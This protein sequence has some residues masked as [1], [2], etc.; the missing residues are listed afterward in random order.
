[1]ERLI[2]FAK[3]HWTSIIL[4]VV[5]AVGI[6][7]LLYPTLSDM[8]NSRSHTRAIVNYVESVDL[9]KTEEL[10]ELREQ[11]QRYNNNLLKK[12]SR[13]HPDGAEHA[14]YMNLLNPSA[15]SIMAYLS[16]PK[17]SVS[18]PVYHTTDETVLQKAVGHFEGSSLP[19]GGE[20]TH[21]V[22]SGH[23]GLPSA[24]L[25][26]DLDKMLIGDVFQI[27][28]LEETLTYEIDQ[29]LITE[30]GDI[31]ALDIIDGED[32]CTI[33]TCT[34]YGI[35]T[36]RLLV[37]GHRIETDEEYVIDVTG[38]AMR[39]DSALVAPFI[40]APILLVL[41][42]VLLVKTNKKKKK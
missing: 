8:W 9:M 40:A 39:I 30:P 19:V 32:Y 22:L 16:I 2:R 29:I 11:A 5:F 24:L 38:D 18:L 1:M 3:N 41:L 6:S 4:I 20:S 21:S 34:P 17:I 33:A 25:L 10:Q 42:V 28:V 7:L 35:N 12:I 13:W 31:S 27:K 23:R 37:R 14:E 26:T 15:N 36:Q